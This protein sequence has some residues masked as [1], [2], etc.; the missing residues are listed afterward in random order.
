MLHFR[1]SK[2]GRLIDIGLVGRLA[3][4]VDQAVGQVPVLHQPIVHTLAGDGYSYSG[5][6]AMLKRAHAKVRAA[7]TASRGPLAKMPPFGFRDLKGK[8]DL[9]EDYDYKSLRAGEGER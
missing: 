6:S 7:H 8:G 3:E 1:Q 4:L 9:R 2:T 5:L